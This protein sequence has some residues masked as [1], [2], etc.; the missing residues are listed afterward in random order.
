MNEKRPDPRITDGALRSALTARLRRAWRLPALQIGLLLAVLL[1]MLWACIVW[2]LKASKHRLEE[3]N[4]R[5]T[6]NLLRLY[7]E[8]VRSSIRSIDLTML[9]LRDRWQDKGPNRFASE[10]LLQQQHLESK[11]IFQVAIIDAF[12][13]LAFTNTDPSAKPVDL[14]DREHF[15]VHRDADARDVL[16]ISR[17]VLGRVT[18]R[19]TIQLTR[20]LTDAAGRF[21]GVIVL[22]IP[23]DYFTRFSRAYDLG[24]DSTVSMVRSNSELLIRSPV[25]P[26]GMDTVLHQF[27]DRIRAIS[28]GQEEVAPFEATSEI[29][30]VL[31]LFAVRAMPEYGLVMFMGRSVP[32][33]MEPYQRQRLLHGSTGGVISV[34]LTAMGYLLW[35]GLRQRSRTRDALEESEYRWKHALKGSSD[36]IWDWNVAS[37]TVYY[38]GNWQ[39][40]LGYAPGEIGDDAQAWRR[41]VHPEDGFAVDAALEDHLAGRIQEYAAEFRMRCR[42]GGWCWMHSRGMAAQRDRLGRAVRVIGTYEDIT[43]RKHAEEA[44]QLAVLVYENSHEGLLV[45]DAN[46]AILSVNRAFTALTGYTAEDIVGRS[47]DVLLN[48]GDADTPLQHETLWRTVRTTGHWQGEIWSRRKNAG[49]YAEWLSISTIYDRDNRPHRRVA[50]FSDLASKKEY[51]QIIWQQAHCDPLTG[52]LNRRIFRERLERDIEKAS[53]DRRTMALLYLDLDH[54]KEVND[55]LGHSVGDALL[56]Q[57]AERLLECALDGD[58]VARLGG[59]EFAIMTGAADPEALAQAILQRMSEPFDL[60]QETAFISGSVGIIQYPHANANAETLLRDADQAMY[61]AKAH[62]RNCYQVFNSSMHEAAQQ[63]MRLVSDLRNAVPE[64]QLHVVYQPIVELA[65][66][67]IHKAEALVRWM[68]PTRGLV[69]PAEFIPIAE[70]TGVIHAIGDMVFQE[71][72]RKLAEL[73]RRHDPHFQMSLNKSPAQFIGNHQL[74]KNWLTTLQEMGLPGS[75]IAL[76]ITEGML[77]DVGATGSLSGKL[78]AFRDAGVQLSLDDFGTG[79]SSLSYL[80]KFDIDFLKIDQSFVR[81]LSESSSDL[82]LCRAIVSMAHALGLKVVAEG[83]ETAQQ[84]DLLTGMGCDYGQGY[85]FSRPVPFEALDKL[86]GEASKLP[87]FSAM[88]CDPAL[89][90]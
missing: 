50:L 55:T 44:M 39:S 22:S 57:A 83:I 9:N 87:L 63:R 76:E 3:E 82:V 38:S 5:D 70:Q 13:K 23:A 16:F 2:E 46:N 69:S 58:S 48:T 49:I 20:R 62:G 37:D 35:A 72:V 68:H 33:L 54:F 79:Y 52:L 59:D 24:G 53:R 42:D 88:E 27:P 75:S 80:K 8:E 89:S 17:P 36:G 4:S 51:E 28:Y 85:L 71:C 77:L 29:D 25:P 10:V 19:W 7:T 32:L 26:Q 65:T 47:I 34:L 78:A 18:Q 74:Y 66:G 61:A 67:S 31:R 1:P 40:M 21:T 60:G 56:Q 86:L 12:G 30:G 43:E 14:S 90:I 41:L 73:R 15:K 11:V 64:G 81:N 6:A 84:R 45:M